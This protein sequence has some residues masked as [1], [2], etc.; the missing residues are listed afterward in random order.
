MIPKSL[1]FGFPLT[2]IVFLH[3]L[4]VYYYCLW[5]L[6]CSH[7]ILIFAPYYYYFFPSFSVLQKTFSLQAW[8]RKKSGGT[9]QVRFG[10]FTLLKRLAH[11][12]HNL[13]TFGCEIP[14]AH[15]EGQEADSVMIVHIL[16]V[17]IF[18]FFPSSSCIEYDFPVKKKK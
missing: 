16:S 5:W 3:L 8:R 12:A 13:Q 9:L 1:S 17:L 18:F 11:C 15:N 2:T 7:Q 10:S 4:E 14:V 6:E